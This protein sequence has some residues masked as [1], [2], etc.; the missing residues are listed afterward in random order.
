[1][2]V[3]ASLRASGWFVRAHGLFVGAAVGDY[4]N[5]DCWASVW[6]LWPTWKITLHGANTLKMQMEIGGA[7]NEYSST[8]RMRV[9]AHHCADA[10]LKV[11][12][13]DFYCTGVRRFRPVR[14][15]PI[16]A[17]SRDK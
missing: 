5:A 2:R 9:S 13:S 12:F 1:M 16:P 6:A 10:F 17:E 4:R 15:Q 3:N 7:I 8:V 11:S 14:R